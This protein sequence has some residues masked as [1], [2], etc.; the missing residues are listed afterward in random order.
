MLEVI[1][2]C[3]VGELIDEIDSVTTDAIDWNTIET[4]MFRT[5]LYP[6]NSNTYITTKFD[7][8]DT[9]I[10]WLNEALTKILAEAG[11]TG[12]YITNAI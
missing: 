11:L 1:Q 3:E 4:A 5:H 7:G 8:I 9:D 2:A 10:D 6:T 12:V